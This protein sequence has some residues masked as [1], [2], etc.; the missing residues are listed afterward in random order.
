MKK[1]ETGLSAGKF[2]EVIVVGAGAAG[3]GMAV[4]LQDAG[5]DDVLVIDRHEIGASFARWPRE[6]T[7]L[8]PSFPSNS[9]G[10][11]DLNAVTIRTSPAFTLGQEHPDGE[12]FAAYLQAVAEYHELTVGTNTEVVTVEKL[13]DEFVL[14]TNTGPLRCRFLIWAAGEFQYPRRSP[15]PGAELCQHSSLIRSYQRMTGREFLVIGGYESGIDAAI[16]LSSFAKKV[17][18]LSREATWDSESSDPSVALSVYTQ[19]RLEAAT[20]KGGT[21]KLVSDADVVRVECRRGRYLVSTANGKTRTSPTPPILATGFV[22]S[23]QLVKELYEPRDGGYPTL[24]ENDE[25]TTTSGLFFCGPL[26]RHDEQVFCFIYKF[27]MRF[28][29]VAKEI[30]TRLGLEAEDLE[31]YRKKGM[32]LDDLS[33]CGEECEC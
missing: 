10:L 2:H 4:T 11:L 24:T 27:R 33:C 8:T 16:Q 13:D 32:Y 25:S 17:T 23:H 22:G 31:E 15:F 9:V 6:M 5:I 26:V 3:V 19:E 12:S 20:D 21:I 29:V 28:A 18:V 14:T 7:F 1:Q 30:A